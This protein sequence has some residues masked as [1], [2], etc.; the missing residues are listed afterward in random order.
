MTAG[1]PHQ[2]S[3]AKRPRTTARRIGNNTVLSTIASNSG[4]VTYFVE[5]RRDMVAVPRITKIRV[6]D[7]VARLNSWGGLSA[8]PEYNPNNPYANRN[9]NRKGPNRRY[10]LQSDMWVKRL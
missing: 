10:G 3:C 7:N 2:S 8:T 4:H 5:A 6:E 1:I 9:T